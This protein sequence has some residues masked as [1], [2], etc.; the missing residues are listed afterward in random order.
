[1]T[2]LVLS[3]LIHNTPAFLQ[4]LGRRVATV[5]EGLDEARAMAERFKSLSRMSDAELASHGLKRA[6]IPRA[7]LAGT[8]A[9][10]AGHPR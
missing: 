1:M 3:Q 10:L 7:V 9:S 2:T 4:R 5:L 6:D 8:R